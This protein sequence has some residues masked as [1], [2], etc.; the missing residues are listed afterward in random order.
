[1]TNSQI[2]KCIFL[3]RAAERHS[4]IYRPPKTCAIPLLKELTPFCYALI[5][6]FAFSNRKDTCEWFHK[7]DQ[8]SWHRSTLFDLS[9]AWK[10]PPITTQ[11]KVHGPDGRDMVLENAAWRGPFTL[12]TILRS[13]YLADQL[14]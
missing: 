9:R 3:V 8:L 14:D 2:L 7:H 6:I 5:F 10:T 11:N 13:V 1:M 4:L 12:S